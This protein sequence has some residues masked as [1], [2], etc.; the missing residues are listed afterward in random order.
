MRGGFLY[1]FRT[2]SQPSKG[3]HVRIEGPWDKHG[4][5]VKSTPQPEGGYLNLVRGTGQ[6]DIRKGEIRLMNA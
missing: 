2:P 5:V 6:R 1:Q 4:Y 3:Q